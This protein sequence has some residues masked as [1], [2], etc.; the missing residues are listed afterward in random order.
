[1]IVL[2]CDKDKRIAGTF[3][4]Q[5]VLEQLKAELNKEIRSW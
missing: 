3:N 5:Y 1:M 4:E 2:N